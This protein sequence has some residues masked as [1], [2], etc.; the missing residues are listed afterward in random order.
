MTYRGISLSFRDEDNEWTEGEIQQDSLTLS[1]YSYSVPAKEFK[2]TLITEASDII[3]YYD[4]NDGSAGVSEEHFY[5]D[6]VT[7]RDTMFE[8]DGYTFLGWALSPEQAELG[9]EGVAYRAGETLTITNSITLYAVWEK[10]TPNNWWIYRVIGLCILLLIII[11]II[12][13]IVTRKK[14][15]KEKQKMAAR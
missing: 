2:M 13:I 11:I 3:I 8:K 12:I 10:A 4:P 6:L 7:I 1:S 5:G 14:K 9:E 15:N